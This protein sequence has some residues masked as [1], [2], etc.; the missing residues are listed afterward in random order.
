MLG[1]VRFQRREVLMRLSMLNVLLSEVIVWLETLVR[2]TP[3][4]VGGLVRKTWFRRRFQQN[5]SVYIEF[6]CEFRSPQAMNFSGE[7]SIGKNSFFAADGGHIVVG[8]NTTFTMHAHINASVGGLIQI[9]ECCLI[10][11]NVLMRTADHR[12]DIPNTFIRF[13]GHIPLDIHIDDDVWI[14]ANAVI[15]GGV[16]IG[17]GA[18]IGAGAVVTKD[19]PSM[20]IAVGVPAKVAKY[21]NQEIAI[22][23]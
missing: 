5:E 17:K 14:G 10:G 9:G 11:P 13:Q 20:A 21:R 23:N 12:Y 15:L 3:G 22:N 7:V 2:Y 6:G 19:V 18:I 4:R 16:R 1:Y 8:K